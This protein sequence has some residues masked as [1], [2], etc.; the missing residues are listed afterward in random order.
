MAIFIAMAIFYFIVI[1]F[2]IKSRGARNNQKDSVNP[3]R[4]ISQPNQ[5]LSKEEQERRKEMI[6]NR[7]NGM[8]NTDM[9][10][11]VSTSTPA[12]Q[13]TVRER[14]VDTQNYIDTLGY[15]PPKSPALRDM[16]DRNNDWLA[17]QIREERMHN[18]IV[19]EML[20]LKQ[21]HSAHCDAELLRQSHIHG[22]G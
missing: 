11:P 14:I 1:R 18:P 20:N 3:V 5:P 21:E 19:D 15:R 8:P 2:I 22:A 17:R 9:A 10:T 12:P 7:M 4:P 6:R 13:R 16:E